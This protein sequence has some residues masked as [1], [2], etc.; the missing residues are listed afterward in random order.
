MQTD[1]VERMRE[2]RKLATP[3]GTFQQAIQSHCFE[4]V[5]NFVTEA[6]DCGGEQV[7]DGKPCRLYALN[8]RK[9]RWQATKG[10]LKRSIL[11]ECRFCLGKQDVSGCTSPNCNLY[12]FGP[13]RPSSTGGAP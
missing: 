2:A 7:M 9:K 12:P 11:A 13:G 10:A 6:H 3:K 1:F 4:C 5:G 8:T